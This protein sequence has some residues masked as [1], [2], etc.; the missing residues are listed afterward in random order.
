MWTSPSLQHEDLSVQAM[1]QR[2]ERKR[3]T[4]KYLYESQREVEATVR[5]VLYHS[6]GPLKATHPRKRASILETGKQAQK[7]FSSIKNPSVAISSVSSSLGDKEAIPVPKRPLSRAGKVSL[8]EVKFGAKPW[9]GDDYVPSAN[10]DALPGPDNRGK[11]GEGLVEPVSVEKFAKYKDHFEHYSPPCKPLGLMLGPRGWRLEDPFRQPQLP[12]SEPL[13]PL[14]PKVQA[15]LEKQEACL[16]V[17]QYNV[18][19]P[20]SF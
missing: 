9:E 12:V 18:F 4:M 17:K 16:R 15:L 1:R 11:W 5:R 13:E 19:S 3:E 20:T 8:Q 14:T 10:P 6:H 2:M 7:L